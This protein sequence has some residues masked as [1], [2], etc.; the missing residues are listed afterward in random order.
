M[1]FPKD[2]PVY[3]NLGTAFTNF[4]ALVDELREERVTGC[5]SATFP[6]FTGNVLLDGGSVVNTIAEWASGRNSGAEAANALLARVGLK[7]G[8]INVYTLE[9]DLV[10]VLSSL[11]DCE[12][13]F[14]D[15]STEFASIER[16]VAKLRDSGHT[17]FIEIVLDNGQGTG[18][19]YFRDGAVIESV[20]NSDAGTRSGPDVVD[21]VVHAATTLGA[22]FNVFRAVK[23]AVVSPAVFP[24]ARPAAQAAPAA[25]AP[26]AVAPAVAEP[27]V[28]VIPE[29]VVVPEEPA[30][31]L[32][33]ELPVAP[34]PAMEVQ[35][36]PQPISAFEA[37]AIPD[38]VL[39]EL[40]DE[41]MGR[42]G[43]GVSEVLSDWGPAE[44][45]SAAP[46]P[47]PPPPPAPRAPA[48]ASELP[49][50]P[51]AGAPQPD[52]EDVSR[53]E[54]LGFWGEAL[55]RAESVVD[56]LSQEGRFSAAFK[57]VL[58]EKALAY[59]YLDP[60]AAEFIYRQGAATFHGELPSDLSEALGDCLHDTLARLAFRLKRADIET[61]VRAELEAIG[62][63]HQAMV[64]Q[65]SLST[66]A[67]V[68]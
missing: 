67:L 61:R 7:G 58:V 38:L 25:V 23:P 26:V 2:R 68:S 10:G 4:E 28:A 18:A 3:Q 52:D 49:A 57:E 48:P 21:S 12:R 44:P 47:P 6:E 53:D 46:P 50:S 37:A 31:E 55:G 59:P 8:R 35:E 14:G 51:W 29:P 32:P 17:G 64:D 45:E 56:G 5:L 20:V 43:Q 30:F 9:K 54:I 41:P 11:A 36:A 33:V 27:V 16:M 34:P 13:A 62:G 40:S 60:F 39:P 19:I 63:R 1:L 42:G 66:R 15:L 22:T 24:G 65:F